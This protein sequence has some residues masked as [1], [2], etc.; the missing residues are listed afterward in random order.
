MENKSR[1]QRLA[2]QMG[3]A[4]SDMRFSTALFGQI[5]ATGDPVIQVRT[6]ELMVHTMEMVAINYDYGNFTDVEYPWL[7]VAVKVRNLIQNGDYN[8]EEK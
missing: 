1:E 5:I 3:D 4:L 7:K 6:I 2:E 8:G